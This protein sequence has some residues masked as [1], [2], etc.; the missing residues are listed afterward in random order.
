MNK[1]KAFGLCSVFVAA[2][3]STSALADETMNSDQPSAPITGNTLYVDIPVGAPIAQ[4][5]GI[6]PIYFSEDGSAVAQLPAGLK[7]VGTWALEADQYCIDWDNGPKNSCSQL[8]HGPNGFVLKDA[9]LGEP[10]GLATRIA[11]ANAED[12]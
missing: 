2:M 8:L 9:K 1:N 6:A 3:V 11:A 7:L 4:D 5:G 10:R 12:L